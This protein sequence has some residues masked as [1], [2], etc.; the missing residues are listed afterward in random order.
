V[1]GDRPVGEIDAKGMPLASAT[2]RAL[3]DAVVM[4]DPGQTRADECALAA[5][6]P[7]AAPSAR[8]TTARNA[9]IFFTGMTP[10]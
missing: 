6:P 4:G 10:F 3:Q 9:V 7:A 8:P 2:T 1:A 5:P